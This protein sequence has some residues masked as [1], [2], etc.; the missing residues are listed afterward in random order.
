MN[1]IV[2]SLNKTKIDAIRTVFPGANVKGFSVPSLVLAQPI[3]EEMTR[4]G[5][6]NRALH[7]KRLAKDC[8][9]IGLEGGVTFHEEK[10]YLCN[11][12]ALVF[13]D[14]Q[15]VTASGAKIELPNEMI[16]PIFAGKELATVMNEY[17]KKSNIRFHEGAIG[18]FTNH[19]LLRKQMYEQIALLLKGQ[20]EYKRRKDK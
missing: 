12:G 16:A 1:I 8:I 4:R 19:L 3:G 17:T 14:E 9:G 7:S 15:I 13:E 5:A 2:G 18:I 20:Y 10:F 6:I 11:W